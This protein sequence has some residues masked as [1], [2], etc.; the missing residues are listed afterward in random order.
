MSNHER[1]FGN[2]ML[3]FLVG[4]FAWACL[5]GIFG[6]MFRDDLFLMGHHGGR[7]ASDAF[8]DMQY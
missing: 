1:I 4:I 7:G 5:G 8:V 6:M 2:V 3:G